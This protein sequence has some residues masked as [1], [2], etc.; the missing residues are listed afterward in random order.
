MPEFGSTWQIGI[1]RVDF[2]CGLPGVGVNALVA[3]PIH[4]RDGWASDA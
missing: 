4:D 1:E 2:S 3:A